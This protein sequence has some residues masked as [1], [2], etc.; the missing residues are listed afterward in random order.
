MN[1]RKSLFQK[2]RPCI[3]SH[4][5]SNVMSLQNGVLRDFAGMPEQTSPRRSSQLPSSNV[6]GIVDD[7]S[8]R[9]SNDNVVGGLRDFERK[10]MKLFPG[11]TYHGGWNRIGFNGIG[12][13]RFADGTVY[14][15]QFSDGHF[16]GTGTLSM[17]NDTVVKG[18]WNRGVSTELLLQFPDGLAYREQDWAY[19]NGRDKRFAMDDFQH[20]PPIGEHRR[21][22]CR[23]DYPIPAGC[24]NTGDG[25]YNPKT[26]CLYSYSDPER[27]VRI[28]SS[29]EEK[30]I[31]KHCPTAWEEMSTSDVNHLCKVEYQRKDDEF[32]F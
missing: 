26:K 22:P 28:P 25:F 8:S 3:Q 23:M 11:C 15:G 1:V 32:L 16:H 14:D 9:P 20:L 12:S 21:M 19:C 17:P 31:L 30:W 27:I 29:R 4:F 10:E 5:S 2:Q 6:S 13:Y 18:Q 7:S 24:Y